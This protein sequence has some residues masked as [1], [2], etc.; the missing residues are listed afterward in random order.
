MVVVP[1]MHRSNLTLK[2]AV[3]EKLSIFE[4]TKACSDDKTYSLRKHVVMITGIRSEVQLRISSCSYQ[5]E[6]VRVASVKIGST[7]Y[8]T[9]LKTYFRDENETEQIIYL[10]KSYINNCYQ[11]ILTLCKITI[12]YSI[13]LTDQLIENRFVK[14]VPTYRGQTPQG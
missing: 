13:K 10:C 5:L 11:Y 4:K 7:K 12:L 3:H 9:Q 8:W 6:R 1:N 2:F 14:N